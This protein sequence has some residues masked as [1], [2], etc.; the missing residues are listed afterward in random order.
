MIRMLMVLAMGLATGAP[1]FAQ[2]SSGKPSVQ[3]MFFTADWCPNCRI[4]A[5]KLEQAMLQAPG[6]EQVTIDITD[7]ARWDQSQERALEKR[8]VRL[9]NAYVGTT[10]FAV[11]AAADTGET[12][13][14]VN[15]LHEPLVI[16]AMIARAVTRVATRPAHQRADGRDPAC[17]AERAPPS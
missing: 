16:R 15:R 2:A 4:I 5:P 17:P 14:C 13:A 8:L 11:I 7:S 6:A 12:I 10:G 3:V 9:Y 1:A